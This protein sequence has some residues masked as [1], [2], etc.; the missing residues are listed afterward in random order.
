MSKPKIKFCCDVWPKI[1]F[2]L[3]WFSYEENPDQF[4]MPCLRG[5]DGADWR[6]Q[7]CPACGKPV[8]DIEMTRQEVY[9]L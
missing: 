9:D 8:R 7:F 1:A 2:K 3:N 6:V 5:L 4:T